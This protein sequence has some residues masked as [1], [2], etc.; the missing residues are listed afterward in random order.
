MA[1]NSRLY[2]FGEQVQ[3]RVEDAA[4]AAVNATTE[5][6]AA[7]AR[8]NHRG[9]KNITGKAEASIQSK[10]ARLLRRRIRGSLEAGAG[11]AFYF[12]ILEVKH[13]S[14][15]RNAADVEFPNVQERLHQR[16]QAGVG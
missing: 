10:P 16:F 6:A 3:A 15:L 5:A 11:D 14:A 2:W 9:W 12:L 1:K 7:H 4:V 8:A 13:G